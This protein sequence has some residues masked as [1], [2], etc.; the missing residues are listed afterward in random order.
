MSTAC[1]RPPFCVSP[2]WFV[3]VWV[4]R[5]I[6]LLIVIIALACVCQSIVAHNGRLLRETRARVRS[7]P[8]SRVWVCYV[9]CITMNDLCVR[10][11]VGCPNP[12]RT[13]AFA[14]YLARLWVWAIHWCSED[15]QGLRIHTFVHIQKTYTATHKAN[16]NCVFTC[17]LVHKRPI[18]L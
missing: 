5:V 11:H 4:S 2:L 9:K 1:V 7:F 8:C 14:A 6:I 12:F 17:L 10:H 16:E 3:D 15:S 18:H 13:S